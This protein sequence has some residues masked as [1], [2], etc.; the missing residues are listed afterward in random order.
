VC[1]G[2]WGEDSIPPTDLRQ[3]GHVLFMHI[4]RG[5]SEVLLE[6]RGDR[7]L[8]CTVLYCREGVGECLAR[9]KDDKGSPSSLG[10]LLCCR[11]V[12]LSFV[13][14]WPLDWNPG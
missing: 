11:A 3:L 5:G 6:G 13:T 1:T 7:A 2:C 12:V 8:R 9:A 10:V 4:F 14:Y